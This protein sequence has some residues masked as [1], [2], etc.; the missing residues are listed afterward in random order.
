MSNPS[1][2]NVVTPQEITLALEHFMI[3]PAGTALPVGRVDL[4]S[5]PPGF[6][7]L[8]AVADDSPTISVTKQK[9]DLSTGIPSNLQYQAV[10]GMQGQLQAVLHTF[11][12]YAAYL[13]GGGLPPYLLPKTSASVYG[14]VANSATNTRT[15]VYVASSGSATFAVND[16]VVT[17]ASTALNTSR[18]YAWITAAA[19]TTGAAWTLTLQG[20]GLPFTPT[21]GDPIVSVAMSRFALGTNILPEFRV[22]G[23]AD[24]ING[25]QIIHDCQRARPTGEFGEALRNGAHLQ[26]PISFDLFGYTVSTPYS[27]SGQLVLSERFLWMPTTTQ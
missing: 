10:V 7:R 26:M 22:V 15:T 4:D 23:V 27:S 16:L 17:A 6:I 11:D 8:G 5:P 21:V 9:Y 25:M 12:P 1:Y 14:T 24:A 20:A 13:A 3:A 19:S 18:N 2:T